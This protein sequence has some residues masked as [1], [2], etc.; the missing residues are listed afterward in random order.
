MTST[1][2]VDWMAFYQLEKEE[3]AEAKRK[4]QEEATNQ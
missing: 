4:A 3:Q 1:E 2:F